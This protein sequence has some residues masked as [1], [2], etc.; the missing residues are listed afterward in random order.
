MARAMV[1]GISSES[2]VM[3]VQLQGLGNMTYDKVRAIH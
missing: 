1:N 2:G 3:N